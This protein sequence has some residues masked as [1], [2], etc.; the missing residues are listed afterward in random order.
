MAKKKN[1]LAFKITSGVLIFM[2]LYFSIYLWVASEA[3]SNEKAFYDEDLGIITIEVGSYNF[4]TKVFG[5]LQQAVISATQTDIDLASSGSHMSSLRD[6]YSI[7]LNDLSSGEYITG[8]DLNIIKGNSH[9]KTFSGQYS[10]PKDF[11]DTQPLWAIREFTPTSAGVYTSETIYRISTCT[12]KIQ[13][14]CT[15]TA[16]T[17]NDPSVI[18]VT[19]TDSTPVECTNSPYW[20]DYSSD[21]TIANGEIL[22]RTHY[23]IGSAPN[24][25]EIDDTSSHSE[26]EIYK[27]ECSS[28]AIITGTTNT[29]SSGKK[30]CEISNPDPEDDCTIDAALCID[31][32]ICNSAT[33]LCVTPECTDGEEITTVCF[34][35][36]TII[37]QTCVSG[38]L[39][40][41]SNTCPEDNSTADTNDT[42]TVEKAWIIKVTNSTS[43]CQEVIKSTLT[44]N[45]TSYATE[46]LCKAELPE[47]ES[48]IDYFLWSLIGGISLII[49]GISVWFFVFRKK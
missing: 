44:A 32:E 35:N 46:A 23:T 33:A 8:F 41:T 17:I 18:I 4:I 22:K 13:S 45:A 21:E 42:G 31:P 1:K 49:I 36:S 19:V 6:E 9:S 29:F 11:S 2:L 24:C 47:K 30:T 14:T 39:T 28:G 7:Q 48:E 38:I 27:T 40:A 37:S 43:T 12:A 5:A 26:D 20:S 16:K 15:S 25:N 10:F 3:I 34:D